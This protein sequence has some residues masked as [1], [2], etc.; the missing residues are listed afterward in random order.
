MGL[1]A[2]AGYNLT[3]YSKVDSEVLLMNVFP[4]I[5]KWNNK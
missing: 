1:Y 2:G 4:I 3:F 5:Q